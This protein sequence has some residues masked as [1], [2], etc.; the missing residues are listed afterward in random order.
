MVHLVQYIF[1][2]TAKTKYV[3]W[4]FCRSRCLSCLCGCAHACV[5]AVT[6]CWA[7]RTVML[8]LPIIFFV[9]V[10]LTPTRY[11]LCV[12]VVE[13]NYIY[14]ILSVIMARI[15][16]TSVSPHKISTHYICNLP[17]V[18]YQHSLFSD[19]KWTK[20]SLLTQ[21][22][23][24]VFNKKQRFQFITHTSKNCCWLK[25]TTMFPC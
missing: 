12:R 23:Q 24:S 3:F 4:L 14:F 18:I 7:G 25:R 15:W 13:C 16:I 6:P 8:Y 1:K 2:C 9:S 20:C 5:T 21:Q 19:S 11:T 10:M 17:L 22:Q